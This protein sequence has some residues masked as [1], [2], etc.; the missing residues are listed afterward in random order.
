MNLIDWFLNLFRD[1]VS[2][3]AFVADPDRE[4]HQAG[5]GNVSAAQ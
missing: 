5:F 3:A 4:L 2:A 1:P